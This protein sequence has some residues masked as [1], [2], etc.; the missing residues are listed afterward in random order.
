MPEFI[1]TRSS[2]IPAKITGTLVGSSASKN[3]EIPDRETSNRQW[4]TMDVYRLDS[5]TYVAH[6]K[7]RAGSRISREEPCDRVYTGPD[8]GSLLNSLQ[9]LDP[10]VEF[11]VGWPGDG[12]PDQNHGRDFRKHDKSV[13]Q[14]AEI[15]WENLLERSMHMFGVAEEIK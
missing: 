5:G 4:F 14:Y 12:H 15:E 13:C 3:S 2:E 9:S 7:Y 1:L 10:V 8:G 6:V 11:V